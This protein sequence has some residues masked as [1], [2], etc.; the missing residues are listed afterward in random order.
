MLGDTLGALILLEDYD[1]GASGFNVVVEDHGVELQ[2]TLDWSAG[3]VKSMDMG[4]GRKTELTW[5]E[6]NFTPPRRLWET[7]MVMLP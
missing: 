4:R 3:H 1:F 2:E 7:I 6:H 5:C